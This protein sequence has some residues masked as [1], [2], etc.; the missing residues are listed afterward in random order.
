LLI[1]RVRR[2]KEPP[3]V[4]QGKTPPT[5]PLTPGERRAML[6]A[7]L[8]FV[9]LIAV[10]V[11][12]WAMT[13]HSSG[14]GRSGDRCV[15][16][17]IASSMGGAVEHACGAEARDWCRAVSAQHDAHSEAVQAQCRIVGIVP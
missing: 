16:V 10:G 12:A 7:A 4:N 14:Y 9:A 17:T 5:N 8:I 15:N 11:A 3:T 6:I 13:G 1:D 2:T